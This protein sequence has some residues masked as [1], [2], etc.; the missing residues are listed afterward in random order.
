[1]HPDMKP[2]MMSEVPTPPPTGSKE[3]ATV[4]LTGALASSFT[5]RTAG[6]SVSIEGKATIERAEN[7]SATIRI[8]AI[9]AGEDEDAMDAEFQGA[10][11][12]VGKTRGMFGA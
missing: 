11:K 9:S 4:Q 1:M 2:P 7:G 5:G 6:E 12:N 8:T 10:A 3:S